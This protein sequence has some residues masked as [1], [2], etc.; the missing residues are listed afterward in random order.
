MTTTAQLK[1]DMDAF[2]CPICLEILVE[3]ITMP[4]SHRM[5]KP[6]FAK[7]LELTNL[8]CPFCKKRI[9]VWCR[10]AKKLDAL[11]DITLWETI[12]KQ[13]PNEVQARLKGNA[14][15]L[16]DEGGFTHDFTY[17]DGAIGKEFEEQIKQLRAEEEL[18]R[19]KELVESQKLIEAIQLEELGVNNEDIENNAQDNEVPAFDSSFLKMQK[20][21][22]VEIEQQKK[23]EELARRLQEQMEQGGPG[24]A[25]GVATRSTPTRPKTPK[26]SVSSLNKK[27]KGPRQMTLEETMMGSRKRKRDSL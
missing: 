5:C 24:P 10:K 15:T 22:E 16:F 20:Q 27:T 12:Q 1:P 19:S 23:D 13:F 14:T 4:C 17:E 26:T 11:I 2:G 18:R 7:N 25:S 8:H 6:C 21:L 9:S 3:P